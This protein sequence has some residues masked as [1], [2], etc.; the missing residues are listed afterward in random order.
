MEDF[1]LNEMPLSEK[2]KIQI[3]KYIN[4]MDLGHSNKLPSEEIFA[5]II[6]VSRITIRS[7]LNDLASEGVIFRSRARGHL[8][9]EYVS[10]K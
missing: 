10:I 6:G 9:S 3:R 4:T 2:A 7:A 5:D 8:S 1:R